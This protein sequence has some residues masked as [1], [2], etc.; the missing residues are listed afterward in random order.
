MKLSEESLD[1]LRSLD[2]GTTSNQLAVDAARLLETAKQTPAWIEPYEAIALR[3]IG[4]LGADQSDVATS[5]AALA[6]LTQVL[7][8]PDRCPQVVGIDFPSLAFSRAEWLSG[9][10]HL[11]IVAKT[12]DPSKRSMFRIVGAEPR[13]WD[14]T[15]VDGTSLQFTQGG[16]IVSLPSVSGDLEFVA[17]SY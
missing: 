12:D 3:L 15:A 7:S 16:V 13:V 14:L 5:D 8:L 9:N 4:Q 2:Q 17:G 10:L 6:A 11:T 1:W